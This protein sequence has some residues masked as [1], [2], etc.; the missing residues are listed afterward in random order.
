MEGKIPED[1]PGLNGI[2]K[3]VKGGFG[4]WQLGMVPTSNPQFKG[5]QSWDLD[6]SLEDYRI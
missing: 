1:D 3:I 5:P 6:L 2:V 4:A